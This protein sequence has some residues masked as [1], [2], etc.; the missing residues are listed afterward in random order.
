MTKIRSR[1]SRNMDDVRG[2]GG[3]GGGLPIPGGIKAGGGLLGLL[4]VIAIVLVPQLLDRGGTDSTAPNS[5]TDVQS[6]RDACDTELEQVVCGVTNDVQDYWTAA[7]P[8]YFGTEYEMTK[9]RL[10]DQPLN[11]GCGQ[12]S[13]ETGPF[14]CPSDL[15]VYIDLGFLQQIEE[16][17]VGTTSDLAE[18]YILAHEYGHHVQ[19]LL[20]T[21]A[22]VQRASQQDPQRANQYS[23][24]LELQ[25]D[26]YAGAWVGDANRRGLLDDPDEIQEAIEAAEGVGDDRIQ[27]TTTGRIDPERWTHGS[28]EQRRTW[29]LKGFTTLD[30]L[31]CDTFAEVL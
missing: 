13:P 30:P 17:F 15:L 18:Q 19:N 28:A 10:F 25:A 1:D 16:R 8:K 23:V 31:Q 21:N 2:Q 9:T 3:R 5:G 4:I 7:L 29:F 20:G 6:S 22:E 11:T 24:A 27:Q 14:Y 26:C 12:A